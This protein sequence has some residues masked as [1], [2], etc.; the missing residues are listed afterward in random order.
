MSQELAPGCSTALSPQPSGRIWE[1]LLSLPIQ[2]RK[3][4]ALVTSL[5]P[6]SRLD[7]ERGRGEPFLSKNSYLERQLSQAVLAACHSV[8]Q[9]P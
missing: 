1:V 7:I 6:G 9:Q 4:E 2:V 3:Q 8:S 5:S